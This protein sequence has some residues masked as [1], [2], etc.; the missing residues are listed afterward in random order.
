MMYYDGSGPNKDNYADYFHNLLYLEEYEATQQLQQYN[1]QDVPVKI[2][3]DKRLELEVSVS[4]SYVSVSG[5]MNMR[6][7]SGGIITDLD[8]HMKACLGTVPLTALL[9][10]PLVYCAPWYIFLV[11]L[12]PISLVLGSVISSTHYCVCS[13]CQ[14]WF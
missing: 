6:D 1:M 4:I 3:T 9:S 7:V 5:T 12:H 13:R 11:Y 10:M 2:A 8:L 14:V